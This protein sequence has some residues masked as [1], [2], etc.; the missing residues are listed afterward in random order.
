[1]TR[2]QYNANICQC[3]GRPKFTSRLI[4]H[5]SDSIRA[6]KELVILY[7]RST[8]TCWLRCSR[9]GH[10]LQQHLFIDL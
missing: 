7:R 4:V 5:W 10:A 3:F 8:F 1:L 6:D 9:V 2:R